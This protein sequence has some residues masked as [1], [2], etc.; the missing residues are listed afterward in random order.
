VNRRSKPT[1]LSGA[2]VISAC[3]LQV[4]YML[5][6]NRWLVLG[7]AAL[8]GLVLAGQ[9]FR[10]DLSSVRIC[11]SG[12]QRARAGDPVALTL[13]VHN[14]GRRTLPASRLR[15][16]LNG[17]TQEVRVDVDPVP[18]KGVARAALAPTAAT[19]G[20]YGGSVVTCSTTDPLGLLSSR[21]SWASARE[22]LVQPVLVEP[23]EPVLSSSGS[24]TGGRA[25]L[26][27]TQEVAG[28][29]PWRDGEDPRAVHWRASARRGRLVVVERDV[30]DVPTRW[31][32]LLV[33]T[34]GGPR[35]EAALALAAATWVD[36][37]RRGHQVSVL[38]WQGDGSRY[39]EPDVA[40]QSIADWFARIGVLATPSTAQ[41]LESLPPWC[42]AATV[43]ASSS[44]PAGW[45]DDLLQQGSRRQV[46]ITTELA[47]RPR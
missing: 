33:G 10:P 14:D 11:V 34:P 37:V 41:V 31:V 5:T 47:V 36:Q 25:C 17:T 23:A 26:S 22:L 4:L 7:A 29:R 13:H 35:D 12:E 42:D 18:A 40:P 1:A 16:V 19:R 44:T 30:P 20:A 39:A 2:L 3:V 43:L 28:L 8:A 45:L 15:L 32:A 9:L 38:A 24:S 6:G 27:G 21:R 46:R